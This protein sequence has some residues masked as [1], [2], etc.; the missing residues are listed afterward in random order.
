MATLAPPQGNVPPQPKNCEDIISHIP[1]PPNH[2]CSTVTVI[3]PA[4]KQPYFNAYLCLADP[5]ARLFHQSRKF[6][7][8]MRM[9]SFFLFYICFHPASRITTTH[10]QYRVKNGSNVNR[11]IILYDL[12][13]AQMMTPWD[14]KQ[15]CP[16]PTFADKRD[17]ED[18]ASGACI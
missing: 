4:P 8:N 15:N 14:C 9:K 10:L 12:F 6:W 13:H 16:C 17:K 1:T 18:I 5:R 7:E 11:W 2:D 3:I